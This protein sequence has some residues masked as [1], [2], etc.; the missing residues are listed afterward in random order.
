[1]FVILDQKTNNR[2]SI[3]KPIKAKTRMYI[4]TS[5]RIS[6]LNKIK[7][8]NRIS[9]LTP[10]KVN[11][12]LN[13]ENQTSKQT[14]SKKVFNGSSWNHVRVQSEFNQMQVLKDTK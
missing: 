5:N 14:T 12:F 9:I 13:K 2:I 8:K 11:K 1:M 6:I 3:L 10:I 4:L 7:A